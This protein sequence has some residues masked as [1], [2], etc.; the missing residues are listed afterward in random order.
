[1]FSFH[2]NFK[3]TYKDLNGESRIRTEGAREDT[4]IFKTNAI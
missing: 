4:L 3:K 2:N 1:M